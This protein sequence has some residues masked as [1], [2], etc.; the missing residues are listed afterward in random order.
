VERAG[1]SLLAVRREPVAAA[2]PDRLG[3]EPAVPC[4]PEDAGAYRALVHTERAE[5]ADQRREP[6]GATVR[7]ERVAPDRHDQRR[8]AGRIGGELAPDPAGERSIAS[9]L[10]KRRDGHR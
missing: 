6:R 8:D 7:H 3:G 5:Q 1:E 2:A 4:D 9:R 10:G